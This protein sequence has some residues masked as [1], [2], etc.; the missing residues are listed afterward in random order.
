MPPSD[1]DGL[2]VCEQGGGGGGLG[3]LRRHD[4]SVEQGLPPHPD[5]SED[6]ALIVDVVAGK[7]RLSSVLAWFGRAGDAEGLASVIREIPRDPEFAD[8]LCEGL[9]HLRAA[10]KTFFSRSNRQ[11]TRTGQ[12]P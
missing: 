12:T 11:D 1:R 9:A 8:L 7:L 4:L 2:S 3:E 5:L 6:A 10:D